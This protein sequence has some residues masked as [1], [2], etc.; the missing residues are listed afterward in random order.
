MKVKSWVS[1]RAERK[2]GT[3]EGRNIFLAI[4]E[5]STKRLQLELDKINFKNM[6]TIRTLRVRF[7]NKSET[8]KENLYLPA[9]VSGRMQLKVGGTRVTRKQ[10]YFPQNHSFI[11]RYFDFI[12][13]FRLLF[14]LMKI[15]CS[16]ASKKCV[17]R[18]NPHAPSYFRRNKVYG[19]PSDTVLGRG[20]PY[21]HVS[22]AE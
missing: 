16:E 19:I 10:Y 4:N 12:S 5:R 21:S 7:Q 11:M 3:E 15:R 20:T 1:C 2:K 14:I 22:F 18:R 6:R 13:L 17:S 8:D 9:N